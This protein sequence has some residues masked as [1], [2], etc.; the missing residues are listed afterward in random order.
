VGITGHVEI[1]DNCVIAG[2]SAITHSLRSPGVYSGVVP[3]HEITRWRRIVARFDGLDTL[4]RRVKN[5]EKNSAH[6]AS[7]DG[8]PF[9]GE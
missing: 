4:F 1:A 2:Q 8:E 5:L 7:T 6:Q 9:H 3:A